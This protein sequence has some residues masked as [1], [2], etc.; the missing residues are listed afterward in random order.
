MTAD[1]PIK[2]S[3]NG[4][5][6]NVFVALTQTLL[7]TLRDDLGLT[8]TKCG[9]NQGVC[10]SCTVFCDGQ[11]IRACLA[12]TA[13]LRG[14]V[15]VTI[16]GAQPGDTLSIVQQAFVD[17]GAVQCGFCI[18]GM[19]VSAT[20]LLKEIRTP[21]ERDIREAL[22]G[23]LCRCTGYAKIV[24]AVSLAAKRLQANAGGAA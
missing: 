18:P 22:S 23:N 17:S 11:P 4:E 8:G 14:R 9:C 20:A 19:I 21:G 1:I 6:R 3:V 12:L 13:T 7:E 10:G 5:D 16:E 15:I 2:L 24:A